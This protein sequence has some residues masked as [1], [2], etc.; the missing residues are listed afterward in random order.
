MDVLYRENFKCVIYKL[1]VSQ[2]GIA[3]FPE[4]VLQCPWVTL[5]A[6]DEQVDQQY[7]LDSQQWINKT[8]NDKYPVSFLP[9][10]SK[11]R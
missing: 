3:R 11:T 5:I 8:K 1:T 7:V 2:T 10:W 6:P 4:L 9:A